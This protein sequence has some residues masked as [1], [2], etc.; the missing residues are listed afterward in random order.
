MKSATR[1]RNKNLF[2][3]AAGEAAKELGLRCAQD[4]HPG[5]LEIAQ[6]LAEKEAAKKED[7][8]IS[9]DDVYR[10][11][12]AGGLPTDLGAA[13]GGIFRNV[14][15]WAF[16]GKWVKSERVSNHARVIRK[17]RYLL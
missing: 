4:A 12:E 6:E 2:D 9:A 7:R 14:K 8:I 13:A 11:L 3:L 1:E 16:T 5:L 17:W 15:K 10:A